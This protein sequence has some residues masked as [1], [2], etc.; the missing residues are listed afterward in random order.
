MN[1]ETESDLRCYVCGKPL[2]SQFMLISMSRN[3]DR[4]FIVHSGD[5]ADQVV[6]DAAVAVEVRRCLP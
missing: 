4:V 2:G 3:V 6:D 5:C 1:D